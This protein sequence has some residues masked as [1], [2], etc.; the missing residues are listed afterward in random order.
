MTTTIHPG[1]RVRITAD[2]PFIGR[3]GA[4]R[5]EPAGDGHLYVDLAGITH[6]FAAHEIKPVTATAAARATDVATAQRAVDRITE[7]IALL[8]Q[9]VTDLGQA[10]A[11]GTDIQCADRIAAHAEAASG[12]AD[13]ALALASEALAAATRAA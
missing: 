2:S 12:R 4:V 9:T 10:L 8:A 13:I 7:A 11:Q 5:P 6:R 3:E 1:T